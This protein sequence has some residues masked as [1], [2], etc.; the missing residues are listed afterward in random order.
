MLAGSQTYHLMKGVSESLAGYVRIIQMTGLSLREI[1]R[2]T[3]AP[4]AYVPVELKATNVPQ[5]PKSI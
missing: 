3:A 4:R 1:S 2:V 5:A